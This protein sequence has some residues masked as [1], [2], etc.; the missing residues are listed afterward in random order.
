[1]SRL[2]SELIQDTRFLLDDFVD[3]ADQRW[4]DAQV[5]L[6]I[7]RAATQVS[8]FLFSNGFDDV[9]STTSAAITSSGIIEIPANDGILSV[10]LVTGNTTVPL[11]RG[12]VRDATVNTS[13]GGDSLVINY[14]AKNPDFSGSDT[15][16]YGGIDLDDYLIDQLTTYIA[17]DDLKTVEGEPNP[18]VQQKIPIL[19][20]QIVSKIPP[21]VTAASNSR[22]K[23]VFNNYKWVRQ[24]PTSVKIYLG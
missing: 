24:S 8:Q 10:S 4:T 19:Q 15:V 3:S 12:S 17:A 18:L 9:I 14:L 7:H 5:S 2:L 23:G 20:A 16:T 11:K 21:T 6:S 22:L 13:V 1:M